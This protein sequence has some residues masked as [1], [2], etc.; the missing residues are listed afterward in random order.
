MPANA[1][2]PAPPSTWLSVSCRSFLA[3]T[4]PGRNALM[5]KARSGPPP[6]SQQCWLLKQRHVEGAVEGRW[7]GGGGEA[8]GGRAGSIPTAGQPALP[9]RTHPPAAHTADNCNQ[10]QPTATGCPSI[11][12]DPPR[13][14]RQGA[15]W[16]GR[17]CSGSTPAQPPG[18]AAPG[19]LRCRL[20]G[21]GAE[22]ALQGSRSPA[23]AA[24][25][26]GCRG[27]RGRLAWGWRRRAEAP[28]E[29]VQ[30]GSCRQACC[31]RAFCARQRHAGLL[32][33]G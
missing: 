2:A 30:A 1:V 33:A 29:C 4:A 27:G 12:T 11:Q 3:S 14:R 6:A 18:A 26:T 8:H 16:T 17:L 13:S 20:G 7:R 10:G 28:C 22:S 21:A 15:G 5:K 24:C 25:A 32:P 19:A 31:R 23:L 9:N